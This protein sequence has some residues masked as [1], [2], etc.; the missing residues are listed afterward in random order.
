MKR[1]H[2]TIT[3]A[4]LPRDYEFTKLVFQGCNKWDFFVCTG[5]ETCWLTPLYRDRPFYYPI[6]ICSLYYY[7]TSP[8]VQESNGEVE[9]D[10]AEV[11]N[12]QEYACF[13]SCFWYLFIR[14]KTRKRLRKLYI[15][16][17]ILKK[18]LDDYTTLI[19]DLQAIVVQ[20]TFHASL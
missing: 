7:Y 9:V 17:N 2:V 3:Q 16:K 4:N 19:D 20:Y 10:Y 8:V 11:R 1:F 13:I 12:M 14:F 6:T 18:S 5:K 15:E